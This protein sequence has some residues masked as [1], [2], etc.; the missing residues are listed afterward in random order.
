[1]LAVL[2]QFADSG[3]GAGLT[4]KAAANGL[5]AEDARLHGDSTHLGFRGDHHVGLPA[6]QGV[7][8]LHGAR[9]ADELRVEGR[10][11]VDLHGVLRYLEVFRLSGQPSAFVAPFGAFRIRLWLGLWLLLATVLHLGAVFATETLGNDS[12]I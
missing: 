12:P 6:G 3:K 1:L 7:A 9:V 8:L 5:T 11:G 2:H 10:G 4:L